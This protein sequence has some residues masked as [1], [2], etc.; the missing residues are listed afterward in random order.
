MKDYEL[1]VE[2]A[3]DSG[4]TMVHLAELLGCIA[5]GTSVEGALAATPE[6]IRGYLRFLERHGGA[7]DP[8]APFATTV[9]EH[10]TEGRWTGEGVGIRPDGQRV[11]FT[12]QETME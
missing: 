5:K 7:V 8:D 11:P 4:K 9:A 10:V 3:P 6:A 12:L 2:S 1:Y